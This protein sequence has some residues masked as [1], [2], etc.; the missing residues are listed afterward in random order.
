MPRNEI[1]IKTKNP[2]FLEWKWIDVDKITKNVVDFKIDV[3][4]KIELELMRALSN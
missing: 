1:N 3:Y 2:E 4:R